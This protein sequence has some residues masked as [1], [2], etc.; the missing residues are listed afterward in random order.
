MRLACA[1][2]AALAPWLVT[3]DALTARDADRALAANVTC[4]TD[5]GGFA[6]AGEPCAD[7]FT[8]NGKKYTGCQDISKLKPYTK[9]SQPSPFGSQLWC[10]TVAAYNT[11]GAKKDWGYCAC[12]GPIT[13]TTQPSSAPT[14]RCVTV[15][16]YATPGTDCA[17]VFTYNGA[18]TYDH[19]CAPFNASTDS[20]P[21]TSKSYVKVPGAK[22]WC[23]TVPA[24][25]TTLTATRTDWGFCVCDGIIIQTDSHAPTALP[26]RAPTHAPSNAPTSPTTTT[27]P[28]HRP[29]A[30]PTHEPTLAP[31]A[32]PS[33]APSTSPTALPTTSPTLPTQQ[34][35]VAPTNL[36][37]LC[38]A[39][40]VADIP[41][42]GS[43]LAL[44]DVDAQFGD[45]WNT[46]SDCPPWSFGWN[47][48][49]PANQ[50]G[51]FNPLDSMQ[52]D[53]VVL[54][55]Q[56]RMFPTY[57][58][59]GIETIVWKAFDDTC[60]GLPSRLVDE[61]MPLSKVMLRAGR[62]STPRVRFS[63]PR[64]GLY[65]V[66]IQIYPGD[67]RAV[68]GLIIL[69]GVTVT[70]FPTTDQLSVFNRVVALNEEQTLDV[71][72]P[73][74]FVNV[75]VDF[76]LIELP[77]DYAPFGV[78]VCPDATVHGDINEF[79][80]LLVLGA[81]G[82]CP[83]FSFGSAPG[84]AALP[85]AFVLMPGGL[86]GTPNVTARATDCTQRFFASASASS[87]SRVAFGPCGVLL[88]KGREDAPVVRFTAAQTG[89][90]VVDVEGAP[91]LLNG[92][93]LP[94]GASVQFL[95]VGDVV[96]ASATADALLSHFDVFLVSD[97]P[98]AQP[99]TRPIN[100][101]AV[102]TQRPT[103]SAVPTTLTKP[104]TSAKP[105][106]TSAKP[107][108]SPTRSPLGSVIPQFNS[109]SP[110]HRPTS[111]MPT[112]APASAQP[113][114]SPSKAPF[115][116]RPSK[117]PTSS[118]PSKAPTSS[119][120]SKSP[121]SSRPSKSPTSSRPSKA[122]SS[123]RPSKAPTSSRPSKA[124]TSSRPSKSPSTSQFAL[125]VFIPGAPTLAPTTV[126]P[127]HAPS[128]SPTSHRPSRSP[129]SK[130]PTRSPSSS[131]PSAAPTLSPRASTKSPTRP[132]SAP[133]P[134]T[135]A[136]TAEPTH[137]PTPPTFSSS[138]TMA[139]VVFPTPT[140]QP[141]DN[142]RRRRLVDL[143]A[144]AQFMAAQ[145][146]AFAG[147]PA[148]VDAVSLAP[149]TTDHYLV[150][151]HFLT[152]PVTYMTPTTV[153]QFST[154]VIASPN[155]VFPITFVRIAT[156]SAPTLQPTSH[157]PVASA[158]PSLMPTAYP[159]EY[160]TGA[161]T[162]EY[163]TAAPFPEYET[164]APEYETSAPFPEYETAAPS[165]EYEYETTPPSPEYET[166]PPSPEYETA[167]PEYEIVVPTT[168]GT[169][170]SF[171]FFA[172]HPSK[173]TRLPMNPD[174]FGE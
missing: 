73:G 118:Q 125:D 172:A 77:D 66:T 102:P 122:P 59:W 74:V 33:E 80:A 85:D 70:S 29:T 171:S 32:A 114:R 133:T 159:T 93:A 72:A 92:V 147:V 89:E 158:K 6:P 9:A 164:A 168:A 139:F 62:L 128:H 36:P 112:L 129:T 56:A 55:C 82:D 79:A 68:K 163:E 28:T 86:Y 54:N 101:T 108:R 146:S 39:N 162:P 130:R 115:T 135:F 4:T 5:G 116:N 21:Y 26:S 41:G 53:V 35:S 50:P 15:G 145:L 17:P 90:Y 94:S 83:P 75:P 7:E 153:V 18:Q 58:P 10:S 95:N 78:D 123:S 34:P 140:F 136:P 45:Q 13:P 167:S 44:F 46:P 103:S 138:P 14:A 169:E 126:K 48:N 142:G 170:C 43:G 57:E 120:P 81:P 151:Y 150:V 69:D 37:A 23:S 12:H 174:E 52:L 47:P 22:Y 131:A 155:N 124:P 161:P 20:M 84:A 99:T 87:P 119:R 160:E 88:L 42:V 71:K 165:R 144:L 31:S 141:V 105:T 24:Y 1:L 3:S 121:T 154:G 137:K 149:G 19:V 16:G 61:P 63:P 65:L 152:T 113:S 143:S 127:T 38:R 76:A 40:L 30:K 97:V 117:A 173:L 166:T 51:A 110:T 25:S 157:A 64:D 11:K 106:T 49:N 109:T 98:T 60:A 96:D 91:A 134:P 2:L 148:V 107:S 132:T 67:L 100:S 111:R 8:Y 156:T 27:S 104:P